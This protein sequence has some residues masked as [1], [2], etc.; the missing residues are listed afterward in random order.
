MDDLYKNS[1][2]CHWFKDGKCVHI[3]TFKSSKT[4]IVYLTE[5]GVISEAIKEGFSEQNFY[6]LKINLESK[7]SKKKVNEF[8]QA[9]F[10]E[11]EEIKSDWTESIDE[12]VTIALKNAVDEEEIAEIIDPENFCCKYFM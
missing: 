8:M 12:A 7:L 1:H 9:F 3:R 10:E 2:W 6:K 5:E 11:L 4:E